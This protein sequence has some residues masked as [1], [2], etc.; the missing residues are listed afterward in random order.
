LESR[1]KQLK[2]LVDEQLLSAFKAACKESGVSM[3]A[4]LAGY[5]KRRTLQAENLPTK[6]IPPRIA[7]RRDR[8]GALKSIIPMI[9]TIRDAEEEYLGRIPE[10]LGSGAAY[11]SA[12]SA[13]S[14]LDEAIALLE[15]AFG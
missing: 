8:R 14:I 13:V 2:I 9:V 15:E 5:M 12:E 4:E 3:A 11:E 7:T 10:N 1:K 6:T